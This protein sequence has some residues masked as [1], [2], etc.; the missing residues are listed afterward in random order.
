VH[1]LVNFYRVRRLERKVISTVFWT[2]V[3]EHGGAPMQFA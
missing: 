2:S 3:G 1:D